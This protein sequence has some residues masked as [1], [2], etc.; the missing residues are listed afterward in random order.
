EVPFLV[1][2]GQVGVTFHEVDIAPHR[3]QW[4]AKLMGNRC[5]ELFQ[6]HRPLADLRLERGVP[7]LELFIESLDLTLRGLER[8]DINDPR[9]DAAVATLPIEQGHGPRQR[10]AARAISTAQPDLAFSQVDP[11]PDQL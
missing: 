7:A 8:R 3:G 5:H 11:R 2:P 4:R 6:M 9:P 1:S 10:P